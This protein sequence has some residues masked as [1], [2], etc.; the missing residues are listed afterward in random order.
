LDALGSRGEGR[1][2]VGAVLTERSVDLHEE[3]VERE[4][5]VFHSSATTKNNTEMLQYIVGGGGF[6]STQV[7]GCKRLGLWDQSGYTI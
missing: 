4:V 5:N 3:V 6:A 7:W 2:T 1:D